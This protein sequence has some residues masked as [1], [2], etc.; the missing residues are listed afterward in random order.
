MIKRV[1]IDFYTPEEI[2]NAKTILWEL[3]GEEMLGSI[4]NRQDSVNRGAHEKE[5]DDILSALYTISNDS[6]P[7]F[8]KIQFVANCFSRFS[9][10]PRVA[11]GGD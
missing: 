10:L 1:V 9:R 6:E 2:G 4:P 7:D 5:T 3:Y 8:V 11:A